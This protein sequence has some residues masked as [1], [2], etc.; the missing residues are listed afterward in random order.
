MVSGGGRGGGNPLT[1]PCRMSGQ[2]CQPGV[3]RGSGISGSLAN[4][5]FLSLTSVPQ[6]PQ[7]SSSQS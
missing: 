2:G 6:R 4:N 1:Q 7:H 5:H 3:L